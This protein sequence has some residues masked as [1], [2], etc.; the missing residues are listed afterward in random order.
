MCVCVCVLCVCVSGITLQG[1][2][3][4]ISSGQAE[5]ELPVWVCHLH[6]CMHCVSL[7]EQASQE[8]FGFL[9]TLRAFLVHSG[10]KMCVCVC[11]CACVRVRVRVV[12][13]CVCVCACA[14][15][16]CVCVCVC[17]CERERERTSQ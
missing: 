12:C 2:S 7:L 9:D 1:R 8:N 13:V 16:C 5:S 11:V 17:V 4:E 15:A 6:L 14:C 3:H 10:D